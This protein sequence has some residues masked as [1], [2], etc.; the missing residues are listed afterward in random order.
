MALL[1]L[2]VWAMAEAFGHGSFGEFANSALIPIVAI[3]MV[4]GAPLIALVVIVYFV[5]R[6]RQRRQQLQKET[7]QQFLDAGQQVPDAVLYQQTPETR[8]EQYLRQGIV[9]VGLGA[10]VFIFL[11]ALTGIQ[12]GSLGLVFVAVGIAQM[13]V[14]KLSKNNGAARD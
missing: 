1:A 6:G 11:T 12:I 10:G 2:P 9:L 8:P 4:F 5:M 13:I 14:W 7:I 3:F